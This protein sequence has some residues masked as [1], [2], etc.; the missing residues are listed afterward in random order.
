[1]VPSNIKESTQS[2]ITDSKPPTKNEKLISGIKKKKATSKPPS[3]AEI[4]A[5]AEAI[6]KI[7][8]AAKKNR[9]F[10]LTFKNKSMYVHKAFSNE[11]AKDNQLVIY[12][13]TNCHIVKDKNGR[14]AD[15]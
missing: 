6:S 9:T 2:F 4:K 15:L 3:Q 14:V 7:K 10:C 1:M 11:G 5:C 13:R 12:K 8:I